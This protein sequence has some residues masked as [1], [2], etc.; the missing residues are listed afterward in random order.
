[1]ISR[2]SGVLVAVAMFSCGVDESM[3]QNLDESDVTA[4]ALSRNAVANWFPLEAN[5]SWTFEK[6]GGAGTRTVSVRAGTGRTVQLTGLFNDTVVLSASSTTV[7]LRDSSDQAATPFLRFG[8][9]RSWMFGSGPC[10]TFEVT[11]V[12]DM[13]PLYTVAGIFEERRTFK[14]NQRTNPVVLCT[15]APVFE[16]SFAAGRGLVSFKTGDGET[17]ALTSTNVG[18][19]PRNRP[20][21]SGTISLDKA[22][23]ANKPNSIRCIQAPCPSNAEL[24]TAKLKYT[25]RN[26]GLLPVTYRFTNGCWFNVVVVD[27]AGMTVRNED[28]VRFCTL[29]TGEFTLAPGA[30]KTFSQD[31]PMADLSGSQLEGGYTVYAYLSNSA[32]ASA[33]AS[34]SFKVTTR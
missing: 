6:V 22:T 29:A 8:A 28:A 30:S 27:A 17:F 18:E 15:P 21:V 4:D 24:D 2:L 25:L 34:K 7:M 10:G 26:N 1:M 23:Y 20:A 5:N 13:E 9:T 12:K 32:G 14:F 19:T 3:V 33:I 11:Q 31:L 16:L